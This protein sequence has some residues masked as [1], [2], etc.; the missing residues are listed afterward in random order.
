MLEL[1]RVTAADPRLDRLLQL[2]MFEWSARVPTAIGADARYTYRALPRYADADDDDAEAYLLRAPGAEAPAGFALVTRDEVG[3]W[4]VEEFFVLPGARRRGQGAHAARALVAAH[5]GRWSLT[6]RPENPPALA[7]WR[8]VFP[9]ARADLEPG[10]DGI[11]RT[12]LT[13]TAPA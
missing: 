11:V 13:F 12:R 7:F 3:C 2:Y 10:V 8:R 4:H 1:T 9:A 6:V 5:P